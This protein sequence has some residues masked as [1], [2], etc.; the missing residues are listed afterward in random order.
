VA[1]SPERPANVRRQIVDHVPPQIL[2]SELNRR[3]GRPFLRCRTAEHQWIQAEVMVVPSAVLK[4]AI[5]AKQ[6]R[7]EVPEGLLGECSCGAEHAK[8]SEV[9][10][11]PHGDGVGAPE[12]APAPA[13]DADSGS[14]LDGDR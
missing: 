8:Y 9:G 11:V 14:P 12:H 1:S 3:S 6:C 7:T 13:F 5:I 2:R 4:A 10:A